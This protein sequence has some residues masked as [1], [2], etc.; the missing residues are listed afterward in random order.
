MSDFCITPFST[1][2]DWIFVL[3]SYFITQK[4]IELGYLLIVVLSLLFF[5]FRQRLSVF[6]DVEFHHKV[7]NV[8][9]I[10]NR[11]SD[12]TQTFRYVFRLDKLKLTTLRKCEN[13][14][15]FRPDRVFR[16]ELNPNPS[17]PASDTHLIHRSAPL[18]KPHKVWSEKNCAISVKP[19]E[20]RR[21]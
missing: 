7:I 21:M 6:F 13:F 12:L 16:R 9:N 17:V 2:V 19:T 5:P 10:D 15:V 3:M 4:V 18:S 11:R 20:T 14:V 8:Q 1:K